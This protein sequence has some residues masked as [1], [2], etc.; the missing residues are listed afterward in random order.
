MS[1][2]DFINQNNGKKVGGGQCVPLVELYAQEVLNNPLPVLPS[3]VNYWKALPGYTQESSAKVGDIAVYNSHPGFPDGHIAIVTALENPPQVF[4]QNADPDGSPAHLFQ[5]STQYLLG[6][7][8]SNMDDVDPNQIKLAT[9]LCWG[10][11]PASEADIQKLISQPTTK[12]AL[13]LI[14]TDNRCNLWY[15]E[16]QALIENPGVTSV[17]INGVKYVAA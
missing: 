4:E 2:Q 15:P 1:L 8:R 12:Q 14:L 17:L 9:A 3:A 16:M 7:Q 6:Y 11:Y 13:N 5:R 10:K